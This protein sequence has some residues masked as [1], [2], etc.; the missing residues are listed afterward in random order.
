MSAA[1]LQPPRK[2]FTRTEV[3]QMLKGEEID[4][5]T[6]DVVVSAGGEQIR[7]SALLP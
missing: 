2:R 7:V 6:E 4:S 3:E 1:T 5:P